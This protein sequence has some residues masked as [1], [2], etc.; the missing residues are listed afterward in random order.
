MRSLLIAQNTTIFY[1]CTWKLRVV[2]PQI[3]ND[4]S[5]SMCFFLL[6]FL[7]KKIIC[8]QLIFTCFG[9]HKNH[10]TCLHNCLSIYCQRNTFSSNLLIMPSMFR[11]FFS[12]CCFFC[13][14]LSRDRSVF[15]VHIRDCIWYLLISS[16]QIKHSN[17]M[18]I[19]AGIPSTCAVAQ[20]P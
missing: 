8:L 13:F 17:H 14:T 18:S 5:L 6:L 16:W 7:K 10:C 1:T 12:D 9:R 3:K 2:W 4:L 19:E 11:S 15:L 20:T